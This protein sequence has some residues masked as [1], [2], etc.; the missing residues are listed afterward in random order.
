[1]S[2]FLHTFVIRAIIN[3]LHAAS[4]AVA[5]GSLATLF[6]WMTWHNGFGM[7]DHSKDT[8]DTL[9]KLLRNGDQG[10]FRA[11]YERH[12]HALWNYANNAMADP[13]DAEDIVQE[14]FL[15]LWEKREVLRINTSLKAYLYRATLNKVIDRSDRSKYRFSYLEDLKRTYEQGNYTIDEKLF[16]KELIGRFEACVGKMPPK[17]RTIFTLSRTHRLTHQQISDYLNISRDN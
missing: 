4:C 6:S 12:W 2:M 16:E 7:I 11:L 15:T 10:A 17:M 3:C 5:I 8:D 14:L 13:D 9:L 1:A